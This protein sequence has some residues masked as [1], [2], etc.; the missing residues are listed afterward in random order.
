MARQASL[1][2]ADEIYY[3]LHGKAILHG[4]YHADLVLNGPS[5]VVPQLV[6]FFMA[7]SDI[8]EPF[9]SIV[10]EVTLPDSEAIRQPVPVAWPTQMPVQP[11]RTRFFL[12][13]PLLVPAPTLRPGHIE[14][15]VI[16]EG[17]EIL[18]AAPWIV[19]NPALAEAPKAN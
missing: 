14:A 6:F 16:H 7:E 9:R 2:V 8:E 3:N 11:G 13:W 19:Q 4:I 10:V 15:K 18:V 17:G 12:R 5:A 1:L